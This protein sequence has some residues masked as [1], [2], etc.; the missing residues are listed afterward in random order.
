MST[1][2]VS[3]VITSYNRAN[4]VGESI[5][6]VQAQDYPNV[7]MV[8]TDDGSTDNSQD[9]IRSY[10]SKDPRI[11]PVFAQH[12]QG[13]SA[14]ENAG[15]EAC[16]GEFIAILSGDDLMLPGKL[17]RQIAFLEQHP[18]F[19]LVT[20]DMEAFDSETGRVLYR[21]S[22][23]FDARS[24]GLEVV[25]NSHWLF[26]R[27]LKY[28]LSSGIGRASCLKPCSWDLRLKYWNELLWV[29]DCLATAKLSWGHMPDLLGRYRMHPGQLH[30]TQDCLDTSFEELLMVLAIT[31]ARYP[32]LARLVKDRREYWLFK[33]I[34]FGWVPGAQQEA[35]ERLFFYEAGPAK[36]AYL[37]A[38]RFVV[39]TPGLMSITGPARRLMRMII[40]QIR[41]A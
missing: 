41:R 26:G 11:V 18:E 19:G 20:H 3:V 25:L 7:Q 5:E 1:P 31:Q 39:T 30:K 35:F 12:N 21:F 15:L 24:G 40:A 36:W 27:E 32:E 2:L 9:V 22:D 6:S 37:K 34:L 4:L 8:V 33:H 17:T 23:K 38:A 10:A 29:I 13:L 14:N 16:T 28:S